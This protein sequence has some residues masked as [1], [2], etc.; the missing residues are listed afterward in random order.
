MSFV[1]QDQNKHTLQFNDL[2]EIS[3]AW[4]NNINNFKIEFYLCRVVIEIPAAKF[5]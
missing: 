5:M 3:R 4:K 2:A 1:L